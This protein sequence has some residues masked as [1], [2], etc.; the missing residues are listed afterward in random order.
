MHGD[1][2]VAPRGQ[3]IVRTR[4]PDVTSARIILPRDGRSVVM[5]VALSL[6]I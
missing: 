1:E 6:Y 4:A 2:E 5:P 3:P